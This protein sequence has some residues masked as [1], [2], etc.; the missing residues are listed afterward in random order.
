MTGE[1]WRVKK[2]K[3]PFFV[4]LTYNVTL[5]LSDFCHLFFPFSSEV[6]LSAFRFN[7]TLMFFL[8]LF[9]CFLPF[10]GDITDI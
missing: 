6:L 5:M 4:P 1:G 2:R 3:P 8:F 9:F 7:I 10:P